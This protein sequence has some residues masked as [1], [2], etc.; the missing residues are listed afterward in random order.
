M[1]D[2]R[3]ADAWKQL[4]EGNERFVA[5]RPQHPRQDAER[6]AETAGSQAP[7]ATIFGCSDSRLAAEIIFDLGLGDAFVIRNAGQV[8]S[9]SVLG[10]IEYGVAVLHVPLLLVL[11]HDS[12][13]AVRAA[14]DSA[15]PDADR[16]P[17]HIADLIAPIV[18][19]VRR[20]AGEVVDPSSV[21]S[22]EVGR[23]HVKD[24]VSELLRRSELVAQAVA[25]GELAI[26]GANYR[27]SDG[28]VSSHLVVGEI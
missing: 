19:A 15:A 7:V 11:S 21:D 17:P 12:C 3:P 1:T 5:D 20:V 23:E 27:L 25:D 4:K 2:S 22:T 10:S 24:T 14:I 28:T 6:R 26:V 9:E 16:L 13:G 8:I 18:P